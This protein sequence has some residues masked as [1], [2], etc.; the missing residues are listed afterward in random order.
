MLRVPDALLLH[1]HLGKSAKLLWIVLQPVGG[2]AAPATWL[3]QARSGLARHTVLRALAHLRALGLLPHGPDR[4]RA[5]R[6][7][8][9]T[10]WLELSQQSKFSPIHFLLGHPVARHETVDRTARRLMRAYLSLL[11]DSDEQDDDAS[12]AGEE[13]QFDRYCAPGVAFELQ[14][15]QHCGPTDHC[16]GELQVLKQQARDYMKQRA[17][18]PRGSTWP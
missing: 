9:A 1:R 12:P 6:A 18:A 16:A 13:M 8:Q 4:K 14:G 2:D 15:V 11:V 5:I 7:L 3:L 17:C 10:G